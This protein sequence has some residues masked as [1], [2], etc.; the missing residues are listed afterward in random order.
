[1]WGLFYLCFWLNLYQSALVLQ[2]TPL[3]HLHSGIVV[4]VFFFCKTLHLKCLTVSDYVSL[5][6]CSVICIVTLCNIL[7]QIRSKFWHIQH[8]LFS[9]IC[10]VIISYWVLLRHITYIEILR[11]IQTYS[12]IFSTL[13]NPCIFTILPYSEL[14]QISNWRL[15]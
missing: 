2:T 11:Y 5:N 14:W 4:V 13:F 15:I 7:H 9:G 10:W 12:G 6:N 8:S 1:M 3:P